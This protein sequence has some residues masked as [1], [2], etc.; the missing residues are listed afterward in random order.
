MYANCEYDDVDIKSCYLRRT[1]A[2]IG[3]CV[4]CR[5]VHYRFLVVKC[6]DP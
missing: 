6:K 3:S 1:V 4:V 2:V 5:N